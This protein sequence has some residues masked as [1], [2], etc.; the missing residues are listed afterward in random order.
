MMG[1]YNFPKI[2]NSRKIDEQTEARKKYDAGM[3][4]AKKKKRKKK[5]EDELSS[6]A[7]NISG[8]N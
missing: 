1:S 4:K 2:V 7:V 8:S 5:Y 6:K 3:V